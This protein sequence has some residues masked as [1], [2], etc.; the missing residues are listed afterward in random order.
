MPEYLFNSLVGWVPEP[1]ENLV[2]IA[3]LR[4]QR[5]PG[6]NSYHCLAL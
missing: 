3:S 4:S 2:A 5:H 6:A 1:T